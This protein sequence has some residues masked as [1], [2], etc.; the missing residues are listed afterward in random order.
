LRPWLPKSVVSLNEVLPLKSMIQTSPAL[1][2]ISPVIH[3][4]DL[5]D[6]EAV[7][8][9]DTA[10]MWA[11]RITGAIGAIFVPPALIIWAA[12]PGHYRLVLAFLI[13]AMLAAI[14]HSYTFENG[15]LH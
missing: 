15:G 3:D 1:R 13:V 2:G 6:D 4:I 9:E 14:I 11:S 7:Q 8:T 10:T 12:R 5:Q